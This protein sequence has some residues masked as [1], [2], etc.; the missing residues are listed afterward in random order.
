MMR[1]LAR[2]QAG[3]AQAL[4]GA[5]RKCLVVDL[6]N[7]LWGGIVGEVGREAIALGR[8]Y[9]GSAFRQFQLAIRQL[10]RRGVVLAI[11]SKNNAD[12][13]RDVLESHPGMVLRPGDFAAV[14]INWQDKAANMLEIAEELNLGT[15]SLVFVDDSPG[16][17]REH[18]SDASRSADHRDAGQ[19]DRL[20]PGCAGVLRVRASR[21]DI[22]RSSSGRDVPAAAPA[23]GCRT[24]GAVGRGI[25]AQP[26]DGRRHSSDR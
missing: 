15:D 14:R 8:T 5:P 24:L 25:P 3:F 4:V 6:D 2:K 22:G 26:R 9:P 21:G 20:P 13:A 10:A 18:A 16:R 17:A 19:S 12:D 7:T 11:N 23:H 1:E